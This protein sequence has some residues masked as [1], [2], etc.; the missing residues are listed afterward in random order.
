[1][2]WS[3]LIGGRATMPV[4]KPTAPLP[5]LGSF[6]AIPL[7]V[8]LVPPQYIALPVLGFEGPLIVWAPGTRVSIVSI[9]CKENGRSLIWRVDISPTM[10]V[11]SVLIK[12]AAL[13]TSTDCWTSPTFRMTSTRTVLAVGT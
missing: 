13:V 8:K 11:L 10:L 12:G 1:N 2:S 9:D 4:P 7:T 5:L 3:E 6:A